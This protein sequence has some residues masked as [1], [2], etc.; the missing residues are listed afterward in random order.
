[1]SER[2][3]HHAASMRGGLLLVRVNSTDT[4]VM[5]P[6]QVLEESSAGFTVPYLDGPKR[7]IHVRFHT[8]EGLLGVAREAGLSVVGWPVSVASRE[9][10][11]S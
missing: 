2:Y 4:T 1:M 3:F 10:E 11:R 7:G 6:H 5:F 9:A 8:K